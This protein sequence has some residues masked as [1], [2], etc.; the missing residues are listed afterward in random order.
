[1]HEHVDALEQRLQVVPGD[2]HAVQLEGRGAPRRLADVESDDA[3]D[4]GLGCEV[5]DQVLAEE[6]CDTGHRDGQ[7]AHGTP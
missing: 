7:G 5:R 3:A 2:V 1:V 4:A 6:A